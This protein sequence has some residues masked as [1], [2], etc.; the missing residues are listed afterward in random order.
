[1]LGSRGLIGRALVRQL[2]SSGHDVVEW[3][4]K[5]SPDHDLCD[6]NNVPLLST[7]V[8]TCDFTF[9]LAYDV[10]GSKYLSSPTLSFMN[11]NSSLMMNTFAALEYKRF[12]FA[13]STMS[14]M[15]VPY[16]A[17]KTVGEHY[18]KILGGVTARFWNVYGKQEVGERSYVISDFVN[19]FAVT[20]SV[21][22]LS[23]GN[24]RRQFLHSRD[25]ARCLETMMLHYEHMKP[26][27]DVSS[28]EWTT[29]IDMA[30]LICS[31]VLP[32][33]ALGDSH[34]FNTEPD[35]FILQYWKPTITLKDG[36]DEL[37]RDARSHESDV[38]MAVLKPRS[39]KSCKSWIGFKAP[40]RIDLAG[41]WTDIPSVTAKMGG[42]VVS[43][44]INLHSYA[45]FVRTEHGHLRV[46]YYSTTPIGSGLGTSG[47]VNVALLA[48]IDGKKSSQE[49]IAERA[50]QFESLT[51]NIGGRQDQYMAALGGFRQLTFTDSA[52]ECQRLEVTEGLKNW[53]LTSLFLFD[54][55]LVHASS[56]V[57]R[58]VWMKYESGD[59]KALRG[60]SELKR[61]AHAMTVALTMSDKGAFVDA[62]KVVCAGVDLLDVRIHAPFKPVLEPLASAGAIEAWK[63]TGA[64]AGGC[65]VV[66]VAEGYEE[67]VESTCHTAGWRRLQWHF[68]ELGL[69][70]IS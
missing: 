55:R 7:T 49:Q 66:V 22:M 64:G 48:A 24:E 19:S 45:E 35:T 17:L 37:V 50:F 60:M 2:L 20:G 47:S 28:F 42:V 29:V 4:I 69:R 39:L 3:D 41:G 25:C 51:G 36:I 54:S 5:I 62:M 53:L 68:D 1:M 26:I 21:H 40:T 6:E 9:F 11:R 13:S 61:A 27:V 57:H 63:A 18:T 58:D 33:D 56:D 38:S 44:A 59:E 46:S 52:V 67:Q 8:N 34:S 70:S 12:I 65:V 23:Q 15:D 10:G 43:F 30:K 16:G 14:N 31:D 32:G